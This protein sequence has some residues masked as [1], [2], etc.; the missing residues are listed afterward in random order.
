M[1]YLCIKFEGFD[2][3]FDREPRYNNSCQDYSV[4]QNVYNLQMKES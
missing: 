1:T 4:S 2:Q 3:P